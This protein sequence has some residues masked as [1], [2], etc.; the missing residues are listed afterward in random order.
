MGSRAARHQPR[1]GRRPAAQAAAVTLPAKNRIQI[2]F[3][4][5]SRDSLLHDSLRMDPGGTGSDG[6][7][8]FCVHGL[9]CFTAYRKQ[10]G[11]GPKGIS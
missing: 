10:R 9:E 7:S 5:W 3:S 6:S 8:S 1:E 11:P 4:G 2:L